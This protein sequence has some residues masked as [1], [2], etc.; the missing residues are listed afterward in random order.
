MPNGTIWVPASQAG[1]MMNGYSAM[2]SPYSP[3]SVRTGLPT[4]Y[5]GI[6]KYPGSTG[7][8][9]S[10]YSSQQYRAASGGRMDAGSPTSYVYAGAGSSPHMTH[11]SHYAGQA[12]QQAFSPPTF[13]PQSGFAAQQQQQQQP[14][15]GN[16]PSSGSR[17]NMR[18]S[19]S[20]SQ[21]QQSRQQQPL[22]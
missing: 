18:R 20:G 12:R 4:A 21:Q 8:I 14:Y 1:S 2:P 3:P 22:W 10:R 9:G 16:G 6:G 13:G 15:R 7:Q 19:P 11:A 17:F 5:A